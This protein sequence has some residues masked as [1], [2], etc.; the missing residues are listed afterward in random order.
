MAVKGRDVRPLNCLSSRLTVRAR[1]VR[2]R[3]AVV[4]TGIALVDLT[5]RAGRRG[6]RLT[7][8][9]LIGAIVRFAAVP[10]GRRG[11]RF[12]AL[13][14]ALRP[15]GLLR[16]KEQRR[17]RGKRN[18]QVTHLFFPPFAGYTA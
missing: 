2:G 4:A 9:V 12:M 11:R 8:I 15:G 1:Q 5:L 6:C 7:L 13:R 14:I 18:Q 17:G 10:L 16:G 3:V